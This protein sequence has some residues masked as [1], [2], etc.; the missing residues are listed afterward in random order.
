MSLPL[1]PAPVQLL[2]SRLDDSILSE[3]VYESPRPVRRI[4][5]LGHA[6]LFIAFAGMLIL[7]FG[8]GIALVLGTMPGRGHVSQ[9]H[10]K[11][12]LAAQG[13]AY[14]G[15]L[16]A[17]GLFFPM[18]WHKSFPEGLRWAWRTARIHAKTLISGGLALGLIAAAST[19]F[20]SPPKDKLGIDQ[21]FTSTTDAWLVTAFGIFL[22]PVFEEICFRGF[23]LPAFAIAFD[24]ARLPRTAAAR[25]QWSQTTTL[26][27]AAV[28]FSAVLTSALFAMMHFQQDAHMWAVM[29]VLFC[30]SLV[31]TAVRL[32]LN[33]VAASAIVHGSYNA[34][35]LLMLMIATGGFRH[36]DKMP[37]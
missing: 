35:N 3:N 13:I 19:Y 24:W 7:L 31:L 34:F 36:L 26:T 4:P 37:H 11:L 20:I 25:E 15:T 17:A 10:P 30:V 9:A 5:N 2:E 8:S 33:S 14:L 1:D 23:L 16:A 32:K 12:A 29:L 27:P 18:A 28:L 22:A 6:L 21:F